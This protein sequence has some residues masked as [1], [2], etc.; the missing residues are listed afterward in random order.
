MSIPT[1][2]KVEKY[3]SMTTCLIKERKPFFKASLCI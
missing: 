2:L 3:E 1:I